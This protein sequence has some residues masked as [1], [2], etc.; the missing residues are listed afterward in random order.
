[1]NNSADSVSTLN[2]LVEV[3]RDGEAGYKTA[4]EDTKA[5][6]IAPLF[7]KLQSQRVEHIRELQAR[8]S[9]LGGSAPKSGSVAGSL[10]RGWINIK[11]AVGANDR[12]AVLEECE[13]G[14]DAAVKAY[15]EAL[16]KDLDQTSRDL[17]GRQFKAI[18]AAHD[19]IRQ[20]RDSAGLA[21]S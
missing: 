14:E 17:V 13:R 7:R 15:R 10:H 16:T 9:A 12:H 3:N 20:Q 18:Q 6:E 21:K 5:G 1:M 11:S 4:A 2:S 19:A 8:V